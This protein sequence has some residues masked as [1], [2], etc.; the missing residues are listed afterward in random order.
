LFQPLQENR[1]GDLA[2]DLCW[3]LSF[4][5]A[6]HTMGIPRADRP[7]V[8]RIFFETLLRTAGET[9]IPERAL[10]AAAELRDYLRELALSTTDTQP[11]LLGRISEAHRTQALTTSQVAGVA[12][13]LFGAGID[14]PGMFLANALLILSRHPAQRD[15]L[16]SGRAPLDDAIEELLR[17]E[18]PVQNMARVTTAPVSL[19]D[20]ELPT[21]SVVVLVYAAANRDDRRWE[22]ADSLDL[23]RPR[24]R[25]LGFGEGLHFC[26]GGAMARLEARLVLETVLQHAPAYEVADSVTRIVKQSDWGVLHMHASW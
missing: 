8:E 25:N 16:V 7:Y 13:L 22:R 10:S 11:G 9:T 20:S 6:A 12:F 14:A 17:Y 2:R 4:N 18:S 24:K 23:A 1:G 5:V 21:G 26:L 19:H 15:A 3:Q